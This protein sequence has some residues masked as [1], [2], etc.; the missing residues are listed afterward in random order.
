L[1]IKALETQL[2]RVL[3]KEVS[4]VAETAP[5]GAVEASPSPGPSLYRIPKKKGTLKIQQ[6]QAVALELRKLRQERR[7]AKKTKLTFLCKV[8]KIACNSRISFREHVQ[9]RRHKHAKSLKLGSP[10]CGHCDREFESETHFERH[11][12]GK[13]HLKVVTALS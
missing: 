1:E 6:K 10:R 8:Y 3:G 2:N 4:P 5:V 12:R 11:L 9:S 13:D 7:R